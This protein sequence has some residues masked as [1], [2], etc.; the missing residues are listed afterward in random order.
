VVSIVVASL[1]GPGHVDPC[2][3]SIEEFTPEDHRVIM[4]DVSESQGDWQVPQAFNRGASEAAGE[5]LVFL[6]GDTQVTPAWLSQLLACATEA[7]AAA[8]GPLCNLLPGAQNLPPDLGGHPDVRSFARAF[9]KRDSAKW[10]Q[11]VRIASAPML[12]SREVFQ[13]LGG[14]DEHFGS[15]GFADDDFCLRA[16]LRGKRVFVAGD[17]Y[18]HRLGP[19]HLLQ[20][21]PERVK[22]LDSEARRLLT[23]WNLDDPLV[24]QPRRDV[25]SLVDLKDRRILDV[26]CRAGATLQEC[27]LRGAAGIGIEDDRTMR[28]VAATSCSGLGDVRIVRST[29]EI[30]SKQAFDV[31]LAVW[32]LERLPHAPNVLRRYKTFLGRDG[33]FLAVVRNSWA[34]SRLLP[35][36]LTAP[37]PAYPRPAWGPSASPDDVLRWF[38]DAGLVVTAIRP[39]YGPQWSQEP[40]LDGFLK[41]AKRH[42]FL[43]DPKREHYSDECWFMARLPGNEVE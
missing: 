23:K 25:L 29:R 32:Q 11:A 33:V 41:L 30:P 13:D 3:Q 24:C 18:V 15:G 7:G 10:R 14:F 12:I 28:A 43:E 9:N 27:A 21:E 31:I 1:D 37:P 26:K 42:G 16:A 4:V 6:T 36:L 35:L 17:T 5:Y 8:V 22:V 39:A 40:F 38:R 34:L 19:R 20:G 2:L